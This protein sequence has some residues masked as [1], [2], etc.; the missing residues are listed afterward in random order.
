M[1]TFFAPYLPSYPL[2][3][4]LPIFQ[5]HKT[6]SALLF[7]NFVEEKKKKDKNPAKPGI[8]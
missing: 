7:S 4:P 8:F 6:C 2:V 3:S 5:H 1:Y